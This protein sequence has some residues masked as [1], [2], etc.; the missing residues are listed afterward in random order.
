MSGVV[1]S[2]LPPPC[3]G[4]PLLL[5]P[6][7]RDPPPAC[8][9]PTP[10]LLLLLL[11]PPPPLAGA[12]PPPADRWCR[13]CRRCSLARSR[14]NRPLSSFRRDSHSSLYRTPYRPSS[15][16]VTPRATCA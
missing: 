1:T 12:P 3:R 13:C 8:S 15:W 4:E 2:P 14:S 16:S 11:L 7:P 9:P 10:P 5:P 6:R